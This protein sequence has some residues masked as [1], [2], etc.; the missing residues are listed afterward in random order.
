MKT[1]YISGPMTGHKDY[2]FPTFFAAEDKLRASGY[3]VINPARIEHQD[4]DNWAACMRLAITE[5]MRADM[6]ATLPWW[7]QSRGAVTEVAL[8]AR[9]TIPIVNLQELTKCAGS[10]E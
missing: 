3:E 2:N 4:K 1:V 5:M 10:E 9:L 6:V 8:A 7:H